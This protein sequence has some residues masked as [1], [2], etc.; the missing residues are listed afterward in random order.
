MTSERGHIRIASRTSVLAIRQVEEIQG[1]IER[2]DCSIEIIPVNTQGDIDDRP[3]PEMDGQGFF[4]KAVQEAVLQGEADLAVHSYKDLPSAQVL[5]L[6]VAAVPLRADPRD[7]LLV[8]PEQFKAEGNSLPLKFSARVG[9]SSARRRAQL[10]SLRE[11]LE[12]SDIR[13]NVP[14]RIDK[15][16]NGDLDAIVVA[17]AALERLRY[18]PVDLRLEL[19]DPRIFVPAPAQ[20][21]LA[22][23][24]RRNDYYMA[25]LLTELHDPSGYRAVAAERGLL[26]MLQG[27][28]QV[29]L[30]AHAT[31]NQ[32]LITLCAWY[33]GNSVVVEHPNSE[34]AAMLA[35]DALGRP[36]P[37]S[38]G[39]VE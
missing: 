27:G 23:E 22:L 2:Q 24:I 1:A 26:A 29:A 10:L 28:C 35:Y 21:A 13:G 19:L 32:G 6:E 12:V 25:S 31:F 36:T 18:E 4:V 38:P 7:A 5:D 34:G 17:A 9:T 33:E 16:R 14:T 3:F 37:D 39:E 20:G 8:R 30:G 11:D 15:L